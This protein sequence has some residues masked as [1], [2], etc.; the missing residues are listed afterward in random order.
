MKET[1][2]K[3]TF[4]VVVLAYM[5]NLKFVALMIHVLLCFVRSV[6][7]HLVQS[8]AILLVDQSGC[9]GFVYLLEIPTGLGKGQD[10]F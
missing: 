5:D 10:M 8:T 6:L 3:T 2:K 4:A 1:D 9:V 7:A